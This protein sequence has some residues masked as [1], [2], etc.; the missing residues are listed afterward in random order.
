MGIDGLRSYPP[1]PW[2]LRGR[3]H[4]SVWAVPLASVPAVP[5]AVRPFRLFGRAFIG[6]AWVDY[7]P[8]GDLSYRELLSAVLTR[9]GWRPRVTITHIWVDSVASR[10][11]GRELWGIP[12]DLA[13]FSLSGTAASA[14][15]PDGAIASARLSGRGLPPRLPV[16]FRVLQDLAGRLVTTPVRST[17]RY[18]PARVAWTIA[19]DGP[20]RFL[21]GRRPLLSFVAAD[22]RMRFGTAQRVVV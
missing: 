4:V 1:S 10:D 18:G 17:A 2:S 19:P 22:F 21:A 14:L 3:M 15:T 20:L 12:K 16:G 7:Q 11:G 13:S 5:S 6:T 9:D 8:G